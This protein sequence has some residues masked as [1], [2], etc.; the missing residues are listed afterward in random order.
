MT[1]IIIDDEA[2]NRIQLRFLIED[3]FP[4]ITI[5]AEAQNGQEGL[6]LLA[7]HQPDLL[8]LD[9]EMPML[10]GLEMLKQLPNP[11][12][13]VI[14]TTAFDRYAIHAIRLSALDYLLKPV[15]KE[16]LEAAITRYKAT[17]ATTIKNSSA[18]IQNFIEHLNHK[19][20]VED[21]FKL[22]IS[23]SDGTIFI[24]TKDIIR[25]EADSNYTH[26]FLNGK[27]AVIASKTLREY[28]ELLPHQFFIRIHKSHLVNKAFIQD[29]NVQERLLKLHDHSQIEVSKR[30]LK[31]VKD[32][33]ALS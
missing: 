16:E 27:K 3:F 12:F 30:K 32:Y 20:K 5:L 28:E 21:H 23:T 6:A 10:N 13:E 4:E 14:F 17:H 25:C 18:R 19:D 1:A 11:T 8:F 33:L 15:Q 31:E 26:F 9:V 29:F 2:F 7:R 24:F 22:A